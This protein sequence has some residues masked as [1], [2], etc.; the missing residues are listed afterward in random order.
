MIK[1]AVFIADGTE[2]IEFV[3]P[4]DVLRRAGAE[5]HAISVS[6]E[7]PVC[8]HGVSIRADKTVES[9]DLC[10][11]DAFVV[12]GGMPGAINIAQNKKVIAALEKAMATN[13]LVSAICAAP[14]VV[15][16]S[17]GLIDGKKATCYPAEAFI[18]A[19]DCADYT[20]ADVEVDGNLITANGP[21]SAMKF[22]FAVCE[23]LKI[24]P[25]I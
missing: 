4:I 18:K 10:D 19:I 3:T 14:A 24:K 6:G 15:L 25:R 8:S 12:P 22:S 23:A 20:G 7:S 11:Y 21:K 16:A 2:E 9:A 13:K 5:V 1:I 17:N